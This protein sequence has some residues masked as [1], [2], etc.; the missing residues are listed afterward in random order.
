MQE[1]TQCHE[2]FSSY[3]EF[4]INILTLSLKCDQQDL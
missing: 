2:I 1:N 3:G 4:T